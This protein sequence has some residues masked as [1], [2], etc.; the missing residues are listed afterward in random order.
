[1]TE[2]AAVPELVVADAAAWQAWAAAP[3]AAA[4][5]ARLN[6]SARYPILHQIVTAPNDAVRAA[7]I[8]RQLAR[9]KASVQPS[10]QN[11]GLCAVSHVIYSSTSSL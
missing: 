8:T 4:A 3:D 10:G 11:P 6:R 9:L 7:R 1:M 5:F 2:R